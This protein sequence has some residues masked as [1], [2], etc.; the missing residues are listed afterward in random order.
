M[1]AL[2]AI[3]AVIAVCPALQ[4]ATTLSGISATV[5]PTSGSS[6][7]SLTLNPAAAWTAT[8]SAAW[9]TVTPPS[10]S[11]SA[12]I[13]YSWTANGAAS[14]RQA[15]ID[16]A[17]QSFYV[18]QIGSGGAYTPWATAGYGNVVTIAGTGATTSTGDGGPA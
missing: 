17:G 5:P 16:V 2:F 14:V 18:V 10:G 11:A 7:F 4:G 15:R 9:L 8:S 6:S 13:T 1:K 12:V 3:A